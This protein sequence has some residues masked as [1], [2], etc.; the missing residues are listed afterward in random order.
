MQRNLPRSAEIAEL[1]RL[2]GP[3]IQNPVTAISTEFIT[4]SFG[5]SEIH[6]HHALKHDDL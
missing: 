3:P 1:M 5:D 4:M 6:R 2:A